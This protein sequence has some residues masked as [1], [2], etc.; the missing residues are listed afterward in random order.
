ML[1][2]ME[3]NNR[4]VILC[5]E[6]PFKIRHPPPMEIT[7]SH[8]QWHSRTIELW[9]TQLYNHHV[10]GTLTQGWPEG[11]IKGAQVLS[12]GADPLCFAHRSL[13]VNSTNLTFYPHF[14]FSKFFYHW[15]CQPHCHPLKQC[16]CVCVCVYVWMDMRVGLWRRLSAEELMLL[17]C[18]VGEDS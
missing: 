11:T 4:T 3:L 16:V 9:H 14:W 15:H 8:K 17:N 5:W 6:G 13:A 1:A 7:S 10:G 18:G 2:C 12:P